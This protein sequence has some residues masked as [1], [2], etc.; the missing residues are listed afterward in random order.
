MVPRIHLFLFEWVS[1]PSFLECDL[2]FGIPVKSLGTLSDLRKLWR[3]QTFACTW[4]KKKQ[5]PV[6][7]AGSAVWRTRTSEPGLSE[8]NL[9]M[10]LKGCICT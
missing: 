2:T 5:M 9:N 8:K 10:E 6:W 4:Q 1:L 7:L 3:E